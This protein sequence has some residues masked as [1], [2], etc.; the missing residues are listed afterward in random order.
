MVLKDFQ[1]SGCGMWKEL[2]VESTTETIEAECSTCAEVTVH[3]SMCTGG[4]KSRWRYC[5]WG[6]VN[7]LSERIRV[8]GVEAVETNP[9]T[10]EEMGPAADIHTGEVIH[11][12]PEFGNE[13]REERRDFIKAKHRR[14]KGR[15]PLFFDNK[16][17]G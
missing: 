12:R 17:Q 6:G 2:L 1:C 7:D 13:A 5:D 11:E 8:K 15:A 16:K 14:R 3:T 9:E 4:T 10:G